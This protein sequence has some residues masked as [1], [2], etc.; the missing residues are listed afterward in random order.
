MEPDPR[1][2]FDRLV[3][4][5]RAAGDRRMAQRAERRAS[6]LLDITQK[7]Q[8]LRAPQP[9]QRDAVVSPEEQRQQRRARHE[10]VM[11]KAVAACRAG[12]LTVAEVGQLQALKL[13]LDD[14][15]GD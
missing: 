5:L 4:E 14:E 8:A 3:A 10:D 13:R 15:P 11:A 9:S 6:L 7:A 1:P 2:A 12:H